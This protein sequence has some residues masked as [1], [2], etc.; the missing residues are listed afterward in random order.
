MRY[1]SVSKGVEGKIKQQPEGFI[2]KEITGK[3]I[4]LEQDRTYSANELGLEEQADGKFAVFVLQKKNWNT[5][6]ALI[7]IAKKLKRISEMLL[8]L[9]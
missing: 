7:A 9:S 5:I 1:L 3:G 4:V 8:T 6:Q 2:V